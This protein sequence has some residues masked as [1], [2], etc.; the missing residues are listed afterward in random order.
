MSA[1]PVG[2]HPT[3]VGAR[4]LAAPFSLPLH[5]CLY[6][7]WLKLRL[8]CWFV[9]MAGHHFTRHSLLKPWQNCA[10][11]V[12]ADAVVGFQKHDDEFL[13]WVVLGH[14]TLGV[15]ITVFFNLVLGWRTAAVFGATGLLW[16]FRPLI[17]VVQ[18]MTGGRLWAGLVLS[19]VCGG[20]L[21]TAWIITGQLQ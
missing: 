5:Q 12:G 2:F 6:V 15:L 17:A 14:H 19:T 8:C 3:A 7:G 16:S 21:M 20:L 18:K 1:T 9:G 13:H 11:P 10:H 4:C